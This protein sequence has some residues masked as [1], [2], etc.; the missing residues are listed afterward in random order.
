MIFIYGRKSA[1]IKKTIDHIGNCTSCNSVGLEFEIYRDYYHLFWIPFFPVGSK[2]SKVH[3]ITCKKPNDLNPRV[4]DVVSI[5]RTPIYLFSG[6]LLFLVLIATLVN[7]NI[8]TQKE[9]ALFIAE[10]K[11]GDVYL[12]RKKANDTVFY[13]FLRVV[14]LQ[15]DT[16]I[17]YPN[18]FQYFGFISQFNKDDYFIE[19]EF[20][21]TKP[22]LKNMLEQGEIISV[23][24]T[25]SDYTGF[26]RI[27]SP[28]YDSLK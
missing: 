21:F 6:V 23:D 24:R 4:K 14:K 3:C 19:Q 27:K 10:P 22:E 2:E 9:K 7:A 25:Y 8:S 1:R 28:E 26:N 18:A 12:L 20:F 17:V 16:V 11:A 5:T 13:S 15:K